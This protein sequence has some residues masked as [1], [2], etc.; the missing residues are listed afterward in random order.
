[1]SNYNITVRAFSANV[2]SGTFTGTVELPVAN[3]AGL[4]VD[5]GSGLKPVSSGQI[6]IPVVSMPYGGTVIS[7]L[8]GF[9]RL[10]D[11]V[12]IELFNGGEWQAAKAIIPQGIRA[13]QAG[14]VAVL[15]T[16]A[17]AGGA[18]EVK[19]ATGLKKTSGGGAAN[20]AVVQAAAAQA[21]EMQDLK[22]LVA[23]QA[24]MLQAL[25]AQLQPAAPAAET[26]TKAKGK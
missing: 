11:I 16:Q 6:R 9:P 5:A 13:A 14:A 10:T 1:M 26:E 24:A 25:M 15:W 17:L 18:T 23:Q 20:A 21:A 19:D 3:V 7:K 8:K 4:L 22:A 2:A 12:D